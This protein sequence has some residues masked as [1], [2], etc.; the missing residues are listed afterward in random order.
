MLQ[1]EEKLK[2]EFPDKTIITSKE[3]GG[4]DIGATLRNII[5]S[6]EDLKSKA[7]YFLYQADRAQHLEEVVKQYRESDTIILCD[8]YNLSTIVYQHMIMG[9]PKSLV[10]A[11]HHF[12]AGDFLPDLTVLITSDEPHGE[13]GTDV[14]D[15]KGLDFRRKVKECYDKA[16]D[17]LNHP[18]LIVDTTEAQW[19][20]YVDKIVE[21]IK[22][23]F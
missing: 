1:V 7:M 6:N 17:G 14:W 4:T 19:D 3:P 13:L 22:V 10:D 12:I 5:L 21:T 15:S 2:V 11:S 23:L 16:I 18:Y 9:V 8:R 20:D